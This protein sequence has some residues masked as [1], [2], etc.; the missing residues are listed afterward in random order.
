M[1]TMLSDTQILDKIEKACRSHGNFSMGLVYDPEK[2]P[3]L[4][5]TLMTVFGQEAEDSPMAAGS[6]IGTGIT[7]RD[8]MSE[9]FG[10]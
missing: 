7:M 1:V 8:A 9:A 3:V 5:W 4:Y 6:H 10:A 2:D